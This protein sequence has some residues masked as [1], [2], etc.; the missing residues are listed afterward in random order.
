MARQYNN[1]RDRLEAQNYS[2]ITT[3]QEYTDCMNTLAK[4]GSRNC[5]IEFSC[6]KNHIN[7]L[8][9][10]SLLNKLKK[11]EDGATGTLCSHCSKQ[12]L[13]EQ[14][15]EKAEEKCIEL[16]VEFIKIEPKTR[17]HYDIYFKCACG[18][19]SKSDNGSFFRKTETNCKSC[20]KNRNEINIVVEE[21]RKFGCELLDLNYTK[22]DEKLRCICACGKEAMLSLKELRS[23]RLCGNCANDRKKETM[24]EKYG[25]DH[26]FK[27]T[28]IRQKADQT[29]LEKYGVKYSQQNKEI[30]KKTVAT[31][32]LN[33]E[34]KEQ[35]KEELLQ[36]IIDL[37]NDIKEKNESLEQM[38]NSL[39]EMK[40]LLQKLT[41]NSKKVKKVSL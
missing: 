17:G 9:N 16:N 28:E 21:Y 5:D 26:P 10:N 2:I 1:I 31:R 37:E 34:K 20:S 39:N 30:N 4:T 15:Y 8:V 11:I 3:L 32:K 12:P 24:L 36:K 13:I 33:Q 6:E 7:T 35:E 22:L 14:W 25:V 40:E 18:K 29:M 27:S 19:L 23:K 41:R 38:T